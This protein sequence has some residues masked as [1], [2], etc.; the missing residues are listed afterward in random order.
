MRELVGDIVVAKKAF[1]FAHNLFVDIAIEN[2]SYKSALIQAFASVPREMFVAQGFLPRAYED[3]ALPIG[4]GQTISRPSTVARMLA[5]AQIL[6]TDRVLEIG[7]G[8]GYL[9]ALLTFLCHSVYA[10]EASGPLAQ[11]ARDRLD[12]LGLQ[13][14]LLHRG[15]GLRGW[16]EH[17]PFDVIIASAA[18]PSIPKVLT[19]QLKPGTGRIV[20]PVI[21][22]PDR[23]E[24][25]L[26]LG[27]KTKSV[28]ECFFVPGKWIAK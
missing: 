13:K 21:L 8:S 16:R 4:Y 7:A 3:L 17:S 10:I 23:Q 5:T 24:L 14:V 1:R 11:L 15:D 25:L 6:P 18:F 20:M 28:G 2:A 26:Y 22:A 12:L 19:E 9:T 27:G